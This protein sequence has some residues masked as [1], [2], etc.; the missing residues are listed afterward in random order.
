MYPRGRPRYPGVG[1]PATANAGGRILPRRSDGGGRVAELLL[2]AIFLL[3]LPPATST[4]CCRSDVLLS[5]ERLELGKGSSI[6]ALKVE[7]HLE[8]QDLPMVVNSKRDCRVTGNP[9]CLLPV[10]LLK[11]VLPS[12]ELGKGSSVAALKVE[13]DLEK[14]GV[15]VVVLFAGAA[16]GH[17]PDPLLV[18][19]LLYWAAL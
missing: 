12:M 7:C 6:A 2:P 8:K 18:V 19:E 5:M 11:G 4:T 10:Q 3:E 17:L 16:A 15:V 14:H 9:L 1:Y 13:C